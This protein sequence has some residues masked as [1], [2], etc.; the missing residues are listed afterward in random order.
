MSNVERK[1]QVISHRQ[2]KNKVSKQVAVFYNLEDAISWENY[3]RTQ[4]LIIQTEV[5][6]VL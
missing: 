6:P 5:V 3:L 1:Y 4:K 2:K